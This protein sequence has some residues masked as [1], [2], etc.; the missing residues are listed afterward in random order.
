MVVGSSAVFTFVLFMNQHTRPPPKE[1]KLSTSAFEVKKEKKPKQKKRR[2]RPKPRRAQR[3]SA[4]SAP[5]PALSSSISSV[6]IAMPGFDSSDLGELS[7]S[8]VGAN[9]KD[10][11]MDE[12]SVDKPPKAVSKVAPGFP[13]KARKR[14]ITGYVTMNLLI[15]ASGEVERVR[16]LEAS[17]VGV[18]EEDAVA[19]IRK[20]RFAPAEYKAEH[21]KVWA[22]Q[23]LR[24]ELN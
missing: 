12:G 8:V 10:V 6:A 24:F 4:K 20:W 19:S 2:A 11:V 18:F 21:V 17:P 14:G 3:S 15:G 23:T 22:K 16:V 9:A 1:E 7:D 13:D 5:R